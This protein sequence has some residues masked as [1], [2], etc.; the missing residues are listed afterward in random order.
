MATVIELSSDEEDFVPTSTFV[1]VIPRG[2][3]IN[4]ISSDE[5]AEDEVEQMPPAKRKAEDDAAD[6][7]DK[8]R[9]KRRAADD[10]PINLGGVAGAD[11]AMARALAAA[12]GG[13]EDDESIN[14]GDD[15]DDDAVEEEEEEC[16]EVE[17]PSKAAPQTA[18]NAAADEDEDVVFAGRTGLNALSDF[19]HSREN[20]L[21]NPFAPG[22]ERACCANCYCCEFARAQDPPHAPSM[23][24]S[25]QPLASHARRVRCPGLQVQRVG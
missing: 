14:F 7:S 20:C 13:Y 5:E 23:H 18:T 3:E 17:A 10:G 1:S 22:K 4:L 6:M 2:S 8:A 11:I 15:E 16:M 19:P 25:H 24:A 9:G 21:D 12:E